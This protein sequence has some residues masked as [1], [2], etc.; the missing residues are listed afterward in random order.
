M[1]FR[2]RYGPRLIDTMSRLTASLY[3]LPHV[4]ASGDD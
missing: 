1:S 3:G 4:E 2:D